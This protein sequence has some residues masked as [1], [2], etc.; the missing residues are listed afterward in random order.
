MYH[1]Y[2]LHLSNGSYYIGSTSDLTKRL[3]EHA[4]GRVRST[5]KFLPCGLIYCEPYSD[6]SRAQGRE[7]QIK[8]WKSRAAIERLL[9]K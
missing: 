2:I 5:K 4:G 3:A 8:K 1:L 6:R 7:Y 9:K